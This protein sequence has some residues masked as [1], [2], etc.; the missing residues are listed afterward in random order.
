MYSGLAIQYG[1]SFNVRNMNDNLPCV[2][3]ELWNKVTKM[4]VHNFK[5]TLYLACYIL[6]INGH[7]LLFKA[8][9]KEFHLCLVNL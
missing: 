8:F 2:G 1:A 5:D 6:D 7:Y 3:S 9:L 4:I